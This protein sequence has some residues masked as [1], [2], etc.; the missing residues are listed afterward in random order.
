MNK[1]LVSAALAATAFA[2]S[3]AMA[4][5]VPAAV[6]AVV[7]LGKIQ[8][9]CTACKTAAAA[10][11]SQATAQDSREK[12]LIAPLQAE[13]KAIQA[14]LDAVPQGQ[15]PGAALKARANAFQAKYEQAQQE[16]AR[17]R[18]QL[19]RNQAYVGQQIVAKLNPIY[20]QVM[21]R[22]GANVLLEIGATLATAASID[23]TND[24]LAALNTAL[25]SVATVAPAAPA[26]PQQPQG[27]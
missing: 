2:P 20:T 18:A 9:E 10:L 7:D 8:N 22:R 19:Q 25:P 26:K 27:R 12:A 4:Q 13:Q 5:T 15:E 6:I 23:V 16:S 1:L 3:A 21:Q 17:G 14:A 24:V 11:R